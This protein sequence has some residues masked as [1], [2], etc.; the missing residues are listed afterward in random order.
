[1]RRLFCQLLRFALVG[2]TG[3]L[4]NSLALVVLVEL[5]RVWL[6]IASAMS[7]EV[8]IASNFLWNDRWTFGRRDVSLRRF[9]S[10]NLVSL[11]GAA[12]ATATLWGLVT[13]A[14]VHYALANV[15]GIGLATGWNFLAN[16]AWTW[17]GDP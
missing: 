1:M 4:V 5:L 17:G 11:G 2:G 16:V 6:V 13:F 9:A 3:L 14:Q 15:A 7:T 8:A 12:V 10:F